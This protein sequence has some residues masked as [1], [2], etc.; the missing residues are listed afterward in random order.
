M[1]WGDSLETV[2]TDVIGV[3]EESM[4]AKRFIKTWTFALAALF[5]IMMGGMPS[6]AGA[7]SVDVDNLTYADDSER[8]V[9]YNFTNGTVGEILSNAIGLDSTATIT[10]PTGESNSAYL[11]GRAP[12]EDLPAVTVTKNAGSATIAP[13]GT[14][15]VAVLFASAIPPATAP[16]FPSQTLPTNWFYN[17]ELNSFQGIEDQKAYV[18]SV[19]L[20]RD[21]TGGP[22]NNAMVDVVWVKGFFDGAMYNGTTL[23]IRAMVENGG[24]PIW[25]S[26]PIVRDGLDPATTTLTLDLKVS[27]GNTFE[28][29]VFVNDPNTL[30]PLLDKEGKNCTLTT[31]P[32]TFQRFPDLY[33]YIYMEE[34]SASTAPQAQV[35][36]QHWKDQSGN[37]IYHA[38]MWVTDPL[39]QASAVHVTGY[40]EADVSLV[41]DANAKSWY[42]NTPVVIGSAPVTS[43]S[44]PSYTFT[45]TP[46]TTGAVIPPVTKAITGYVTEFATNLSP[47][48]SIATTP[49]FSWM[50]AAGTISGYGIELSDA[51]TGNRVWSF[52]D[53]PPTQTS[54]QYAGP[55]LVTGKTYNYNIITQ[56]E[57]GDAW[58]ASFAQGSFTW[59]GSAP[60]TISFTGSVMT[61]P[62]WPGLDGMAPVEGATVAAKEAVVPLDYGT[63]YGQTST[64]AT[65]GFTIGG[66][67]ALTTFRLTITPPTGTTYVPVLSKFTNWNADIQALLPFVL[68][69]PS[70]YAA[71]GN[72][73]GNGMIL[74]RVALASNPTS[75]LSGAKVVAR[76]M[77]PGTTI[78]YGTT[79]PVSYTGGGDSTGADGIY[80][81][82][83]V[84]AGKIVQ[85]DATLAGY[86]FQFNGPVVPVQADSVSEDS[87]FA[88]P[89]SGGG[90]TYPSE[91]AFIET[92]PGATL[93]DFNATDTSSGHVVFTGNEYAAQGISFASP[94][95]QTLYVEPF[96]TSYWTWTSNY[97][98]PGGAP[99]VGGDAN[100]D[101]LT[102]TFS[103]PVTAVGWNFLEIPDFTAVDIRLYDAS[104]N[105]I[106]ESLDGA[107][108]VASTT[109]DSAF[110]GYASATPIATVVITDTAN[111]GDDVGFD[112]FRFAT[113][114]TPPA[115][116]SF[117][118]V[119]TKASDNMPYGGGIVEQVGNTSV[120]TTTENNTG[121]FLLAGLPSGT[122]FSVKLSPTSAEAATYV[123]TYTNVFNTTSAITAART[124]N[125]FT[126]SD[127]THWGVTMGGAIRGRVMNSNNLAAGY[128]SDAVVG[129][130]SSLE[131]TYTV[132]YE[133]VF[134]NL[135]DGAT[136]AN[137]K[138]YIL[139]VAEGDTVTVSAT[140]NSNYALSQPV[141]FNTHSSSVSQGLVKGVP[142]SGRVAVGGH[143]VTAETTPQPIKSVTVEQVAAD[144]INATVSNP[145]GYYYL[146]LPA[147]QALQFKFSKPQ[148]S[149]EFAATYSADITFNADAPAIPDFNLFGKTTVEGWITTP[150]TQGII[151]A[152][153]KDS[154][155]NYIGGATVTA[156]GISKSYQVC[157]D[158]ECSTSLTATDPTGRY[159][160]KDVDNGDTVTVT[161]QKVG[162]TFNTRTFH[163]HAGAMHQGSITGA[164][165]APNL[166]QNG[167][168]SGSLNGWVVNPVL[169]TGTSPWNPLQDDGTVS[170][171]PDDY[172]FTGTVLYQNLNLT[173]VAGK[174]LSLSI[175]LTNLYA[176]TTG[177][178]VAVWLTC[179]D[180]SGELV[181]TEVLNPANA[182]ILSGTVVSDTYTV[183]TGTQKIVK[184]E[185]VKGDYGSFT[186]DDVV[187][188]ADDLTAG[189]VPAVASLT[190]TSGVY[191]TTFTI[192]GTGFGTTPGKVTVGDVP[193]GIVS[194][195]DKAIEARLVSPARS[196]PVIVTAGF[197]ES[198]PTGP[199]TVTSPYCDVRV[200]TGEIKVIKGQKAEFLLK[201]SFVN[202]F[203]PPV[204]G[205][206]PQLQ[207]EDAGT[208][209]GRVT[210]IPGSIKSPGGTVIRIDTTEL[211]AGDYTVDVVA[212]NGTEAIPAGTLTLRVVTVKAINF[213]EY[214]YDTYPYKE[215]KI[216][217]K[218]VTKQGLLSIYTQVVG[219]DDEVF[220]PAAMGPSDVAVLTEVPTSPIL[221][222]YKNMWGY[223]IYARNNGS[224]TLRAIAPDGT[225]GDLPITVNFPTDSYIT[226][227]SLTAPEG[228]APIDPLYNNRTDPIRFYAEGTTQL[229]W[230][231]QSTSGI[232]NFSTDFGDKLVRLSDG[233]S[234]TST[235]N[236]LDLPVD[237]GTAIL[238]V[239][240][241]DGKATAVVPL[242]TQN[243]PDTGLLSA[244]VKPLD[245]NVF[246]EEFT[247]YFYGA[248]DGLLKFSRT[249]FAMHF[250]PLIV[251]NIPPGSYKILFVPEEGYNPPKPQ[252]WPNAA[253]IAQ[254]EPVVF[255]AGGTVSDIYYFAASQPQDTTVA[256]PTP[257]MR[258]F[259]QAGGTGSIPVDVSD[260]AYIWAT[261]SDAPWIKITSG[262]TGA[263][264]GAVSYTVDAN[265]FGTSRSGTITIAGQSYSITQ[266]GTGIIPP[267]VGTWGVQQLI[268]F[269]DGYNVLSVGPVPWYAEIDRTTLNED[270]SGTMVMKKNDHNGELINTTISFN[271]TMVKNADGSLTFSGNVGEGTEQ[272]PFSLRMVIGDD[273]KMGIVDGTM[274]EHQQKLMVLYRIDTTKIY[275]AANANGE[276][277]NV[278]FE[279][280][281]TSVVDP[282]D[283]N[284][285]YMAISG[286][287][288]FNGSGSYTYNA[289]ANS[290][291]NAG[292]NLI[293]LDDES[294]TPRAYAIAQ[295]GTFTV[296]SGAFQGVFTGD[297][298]AGGGGGAFV[299]GVNN[300][301]AYFFL[302]KQ[303]RAIGYKT[304]DLA[305]KWALISFGQDSKTIDGAIQGF[306]S[307]F[308]TMIC[309][310]VG[311]CNVRVRDRNSGAADTKI[312]TEQILLTVKPDGSFGASFGGQSPDYAGAIGND[313]NTIL[314]NPSFRYAATADPW[315]REIIVGIRASN[316]G[317]LAGGGDFFKGDVNGDGRVGMDDAALTLQ[318]MAGQHPTGVRTDYTVSG[319]DVNGD[320]YPGAHE[321]LYILQYIAGL[322]Q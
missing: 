152:R 313:G 217:S 206:V 214:S 292:E 80:M 260:P 283:G 43:P 136:S 12:I 266:E 158:D 5:F 18:F 71:F 306:Y 278:G 87:F 286:I 125:L 119:L 114:T 95:S 290:L 13:S 82:K 140:N 146:T 220:Y 90:S 223:E 259:T 212:M 184:I 244:V 162:Y 204:G 64:S 91:T 109:S 182:D 221:N 97:L 8:S 14:E 112:D 58:N 81:V 252:W 6:I 211:A 303:D 60:T 52:Y 121:A 275:S 187:L 202:G 296:G 251:G 133:D 299:N 7:F 310:A 269:D 219:S 130:T 308:G 22:Y 30:I 122:P 50:A 117:A 230:I 228:T 199:F 139:G 183:P 257:P 194:W 103:S 262:M 181:R 243:P 106:H 59:T 156:Q 88:T 245:S 169:Q 195:A 205:L 34:E 254:A 134:G 249:A 113:A 213:Y 53:I 63:S 93:I 293:W 3:K 72:T 317:D 128:I 201:A 294:A 26:V 177:N 200:I 298:L 137:G 41:Y 282:P 285:A 241:S 68:F 270:G 250:A 124:Y 273:G 320:G 42:N 10:K 151:R 155:G 148:A 301:V 73:S 218:N 267:W 44:Y 208:L 316:V 297:G 105:L 20:G 264:D 70:Q 154:A 288:T 234:A 247:L 108:M 79:Y 160:V 295:D 276:Y 307:S 318:V 145:D 197:V 263:G 225:S 227:I 78:T 143:I 240:T 255:T 233:R 35:Q 180:G 256:L 111:N 61:S 65:G 171:H 242:T 85:L 168:F 19:G 74:G 235:F 38:G 189:A 32:G 192:S 15:G 271:Y 258:A 319:T 120:T 141:V 281:S 36:S 157:Y 280:N 54:V 142:V 33:P 284:G 190:A 86:T 100:E 69:T 39:G 198:N 149:P 66:I 186:A 309:D 224:T 153:V 89:V 159:I 289:M 101:S 164:V 215:I 209:L 248:D 179:V 21:E 67:P 237:L 144:P 147:A 129:Y 173:E 302:K 210:F 94:N 203:V 48:G 311:N 287:H 163:T 231:G 193:V 172:G 57:Q 99:F 150:A 62:N 207:G 191:D 56:I 176:Y 232:M 312:S 170:L 268:H 222:I 9:Y 239:E 315:N 1:V 279:R 2:T 118:G 76:E 126:P 185:L 28:A 4:Y 37:D 161:A 29:G 17:L 102:V 135:I 104:N 274:E 272:L 24:Y 47:S 75:F 131:N 98:S 167:S 175:K 291:N 31:D 11:W 96:P 115:G 165:A 16:T 83:N 23:I 322:R 51:S 27:N 300:Q 40:N 116:I 226:S 123:P 253:D 178:T 246:A 166:L 107:G 216:T 196:G 132:K 138:F 46:K 188:Y 174:T 92:F 77:I 321:L 84:P 261:S 305:G 55:A 236:L 238:H 45:F 229:G 277:Y 314:I 110:W 127:L 49:T 304:A 265:P 25:E